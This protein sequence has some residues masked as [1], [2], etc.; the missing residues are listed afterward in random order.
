MASQ[1]KSKSSSGFDKKFQPRPK[2]RRPGIHA[3]T[4]AS[5]IKNSRNYRK[6]YRGQGK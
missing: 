6:R 1:K 5:K 2:A 3:K 4:K